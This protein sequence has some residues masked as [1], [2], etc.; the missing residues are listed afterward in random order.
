MSEDFGQFLKAEIDA[1]LSSMDEQSRSDPEQC[2]SRAIDWI[3]KNAGR[4]RDEWNRT[5]A[6]N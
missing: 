3:E 5:A 4:F 1:I 2:T 6:V